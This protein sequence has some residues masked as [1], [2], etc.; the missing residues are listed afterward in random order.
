M[1]ELDKIQTRTTQARYMMERS[2]REHFA[3]GAFNVD[4]QG[5]LE[6]I[7]KVAKHL[8]SPVIIEVS[9]SEI[10]YLGRKNIRDLVNN[11][12]VELGVEM[13]LNLDHAPT[14]EDAKLAIDA[15]FEF[16]HIDISQANHEA[17]MTEIVSKTKEVVTYARRTGALVEGEPHFFGGSS[18][19]HDQ[20]IDYE[21]LKKT[22]S[23]PLEAK[24]FI[25]QTGIDTF[26]VAIGNLHGKYNGPKE[27]DINL[28]K[29][30]RQVVSPDV[31]LSLHGGS[32]TPLHYFRE[33]AKEGISKVNINTDL[34]YT[35]RMMLDKVLKDNPKEYA[36]F[37]LMPIVHKA[38]EYVVEE[39]IQ[40][41]NSSGKAKVW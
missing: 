33:A 31:S 13:Y 17:S 22:F 25:N 28:L 4:N 32:G 37:K 40:A 30:I 1:S 6:A 21:E 11:Y 27:L 34:R 3:V 5:V 10:D 36:V 38:I 18:N 24:D 26:A 9:K 29:E 2:R 35:Y 41:L 23:K 19:V 20:E 7:A 12:I 15:G 16:I 39:K 8:H 14:V